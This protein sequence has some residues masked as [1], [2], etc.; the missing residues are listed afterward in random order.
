MK[1][2]EKRKLVYSLIIVTMLIVTIS[3]T[4]AYFLSEASNNN[5]I[6]GTRGTPSFTVNVT[7]MT[8]GSGLIPMK[9]ELLTT[10]LTGHNNNAC[11]DMNGNTVCQI[12][13]ITVANTGDVNLFLNGEVEITPEAG[14]VNLKWGE[15]TSTQKELEGETKA[16]SDKSLVTNDS[17][18]VGGSKE[19][20]ITIFLVDTNG[21]Q[22]SEQ[23]K[24]FNGTVTF[25]AVSGDNIGVSADF[26]PPKSNSRTSSKMLGY[27][28]TLNSSITS[29]GIKE[30]FASVATTDEGI[31][32]AE[33]DYGTSYYWRGAVTN[34]YLTFGGFCWRII[35]ING[36]G[37]LRIIYD[38]TSCYANGTSTD[39]NMIKEGTTTIFAFN[40][41]N[42]QNAYVGYTYNTPGS[43]TFGDEHYGTTSSPIKTKVDTWYNSNLKSYEDKI[44]DTAFCGDR[45]VHS[46]TNY[47][48]NGTGNA[49]TSYGQ[50][51]LNSNKSPQLT[52]SNREDRYTVDD[53]TK[54][55]GVLTNPVGLITADEVAMAGGVW[56]TNNSSYYLYNGNVCWTMSPFSFNG[57]NA[58]VFFVDSDG[59][60]DGGNVRHM[61][62]VRPVIS[63]KSGIILTGNGSIDTP[64]NVT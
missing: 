42:T 11:V 60:L 17:I 22:D 46:E 14:L 15:L 29:K 26:N 53:E 57:S 61:R 32:E 27:L 58:V 40:A 52:C 37:T 31:Y 54:G 62:G 34:N 10:G 33:D 18:E 28:Q 50:Y 24:S 44:S 2:K 45:T 59:S 38:G 35:R 19:Y 41:T 48:G 49:T 16:I 9:D 55:N 5:V 3:S 30:S 21:N 23:Q 51:R 20:Y 7:P 43:S 63:L 13:K 12:Y 6:S 47:T 39:E 8:T 56:T 36:D 25:Y 1:K 4:V 64:F